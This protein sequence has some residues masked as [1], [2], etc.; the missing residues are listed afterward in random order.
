MQGRK[1][2]AS[3]TPTCP[4]GAPLVLPALSLLLPLVALLVPFPILL[5]N[6]ACEPILGRLLFQQHAL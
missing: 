2:L 4:T 5:G 3:A 1:L 6:P